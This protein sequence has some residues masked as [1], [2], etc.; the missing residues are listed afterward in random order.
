MLDDPIVYT[1]ASVG[2]LG[3]GMMLS[4]SIFLLILFLII[5]FVLAFM[6]M[7]KSYDNIITKYICIALLGITSIYFLISIIMLFT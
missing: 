3:I 7:R 2:T 6:G 4:D 5:S 1:I